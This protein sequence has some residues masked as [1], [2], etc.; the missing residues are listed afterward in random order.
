MVS[1]NPPKVVHVHVSHNLGPSRHQR[2]PYLNKPSQVSFGCLSLQRRHCFFDKASKAGQ[3][4]MAGRCHGRNAHAEEYIL[5][6]IPMKWLQFLS[7]GF[8]GRFRD[9]CMRIC[10]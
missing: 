1:S 6:Q 3:E 5:Q 4:L 8:L 2:I 9:V 10:Q 7:I